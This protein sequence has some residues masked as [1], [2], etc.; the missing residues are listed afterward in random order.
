MPDVRLPAAGSRG[1]TAKEAAGVAVYGPAHIF[2]GE[3]P[4]DVDVAPPSGPI[5]VTTKGTGGAKPSVTSTV[6]IALRKPKDPKSPGGFGPEP[7]TQGDELHATC[8]ATATGSTGSARFVN[9]VMSKTTD[10]NGEPTDEERIPDNPP[11]NYTR[12]GELTNVGDRFKI[13]Y[14]EQFVDP[15]GS[16]T[17]NA[18]HLYLLGDIA[19]GDSIIGQVR[20]STHGAPFPNTPAP[21]PGQPGVSADAASG[22]GPDVASSGSSSSVLPLVGAGIAVV[23][24]GGVGGL[25]ARRRRLTRAGPVADEH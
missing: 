6:D 11:V 15:D 12:T 5:T 22:P 20:C 3:W 1:L 18:V 2:G 4:P 23:V 21:P 13:V 7:P 24:V 16:I 10:A 8:T 19:V 14:N 25:W 9:A 17:V